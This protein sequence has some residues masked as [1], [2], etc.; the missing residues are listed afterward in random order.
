[1]TRSQWH[2]TG[3]SD[4]PLSSRRDSQI[5]ALKN[6]VSSDDESNDGGEYCICR[7]P[8]DHRMMVCCEGGCEDWYHCSCVGIDE[9]DAKELLD[10]FIC[11]KCKTEA[12]FTTWK[13]MCRYFNVANCRKAARVT[14]DPPS[15][16]CSDEHR[17]LFWL[18]FKSLLRQDDEPSMGGALNIYEAGSIL[19]QSKTADRLH[20]MGKKPKLPLKEG[21]DS[22]ETN[23]LCFPALANFLDRPVGLDY[24]TA[25]EQ[26]E[27]D[28]LKLQKQVIERRIQGYQ[29]QQKLLIMINKRATLA[30][31]ELKLDVK[32]I[33]GYD[34]RLAMNE[35][36]FFK[37]SKTEEG[38][39]ALG[40]GVL[41]P[42]TAE[43]KAIGAH[44]P[45][46]SQVIPTAPEVSDTLN[47]I[48][49]VKGRKK[50]KHYGWRE[51][52][53]EDF[54]FSQKN[55]KDELA[56]LTKREDE[57]IED[58]ETREA[59]KDYYAENTTEQHF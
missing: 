20:D 42:R 24:V 17:T 19:K 57:I 41:G 53:N 28:S 47:N 43:T 44:I 51:I 46:P 10:R 11:P 5:S 31:L 32:D 45:Y 30:A 23:L 35:A 33:C 49:L 6:A 15:K 39:A 58:A 22:S 12:L 59:T 16:Y 37:Y 38:K 27:L 56:K 8:D 14:D 55:L 50:C 25:E 29:N 9:D 4:T 40:S 52:H 1:M 7:G 54:L 26:N 21:A 36:Q 34:N 3:K 18:H 48:C 2:F 13:R